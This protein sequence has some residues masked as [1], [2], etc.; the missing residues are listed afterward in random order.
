MLSFIKIFLIFLLVV[1]VCVTLKCQLKGGMALYQHPTS[2]EHDTYTCTFTSFIHAF[3]ANTDLNKH[4]CEVLRKRIARGESAWEGLRKILCTEKYIERI[5][6][7]KEQCL[8]E[9]VLGEPLREILTRMEKDSLPLETFALNTHEE[10]ASTD[11]K[12]GLYYTL[13]HKDLIPYLIDSEYKYEGPL[14]YNVP[15]YINGYQI[16]ISWTSKQTTLNAIKS[17]FLYAQIDFEATFLNTVD[18]VVTITKT[19][20]GNSYTYYDDYYG[21]IPVEGKR[22]YLLFYYLLFEKQSLVYLT[23][24]TESHKLTPG[25]YET[26]EGKAQKWTDFFLKLD[27]HRVEFTYHGNSNEYLDGYKL[28][29]ELAVFI[30]DE[31]RRYIR[32][33]ELRIVSSVRDKIKEI[34]EKY[35]FKIEINHIPPLHILENMNLPE[36]QSLCSDLGITYDEEEDLD[37]IEDHIKW[38]RSK[39]WKSDYDSLKIPPLHI[40]EKMTLKELQS[41]CGDL[42]I[43]EDEEGDLENKKEYIEWIIKNSVTHSPMTMIQRKDNDDFQ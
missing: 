31:F 42:G 29:E 43:T 39:T 5:T 21:F 7:T 30:T 4:A 11:T 3:T 32:S 26:A 1:V 38:I 9:E 8:P 6:S 37:E 13:Y 15:V 18:H 24:I 34:A 28:Y 2:L 22:D 33:N 10:S 36:L 25:Q 14:E 12:K 20:P 16:C 17:F 41:L 19:G 40:L 35:N 23:T 27:L